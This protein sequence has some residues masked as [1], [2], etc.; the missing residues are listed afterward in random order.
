MPYILHPFG[1]FTAEKMVHGWN[2]RGRG[3]T[4]DERRDERQ[5]SLHLLVDLGQ[6]LRVPEQ[7]VL[8]LADLD[9]AAT[10]LYSK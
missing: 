6:D 1:N 3:K 2:G 4:R 5:L 10:E 7:G 9:G 8:L